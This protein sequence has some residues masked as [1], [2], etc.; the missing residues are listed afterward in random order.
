VKTAGHYMEILPGH[1]M[2]TYVTNDSSQYG[3]VYSDSSSPAPILLPKYRSCWK[4]NHAMDNE[5]LDRFGRGALLVF[6]ACELKVI[7]ATRDR[8]VSLR[9][10]GL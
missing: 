4:V 9:L 10:S 8:P 3:L 6:I 2:N 7:S 1:F 5:R